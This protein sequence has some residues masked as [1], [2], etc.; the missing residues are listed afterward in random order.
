MLRSYPRVYALGHRAIEELLADPVVVQEKVDGSQFSFGRIDGV[1]Y[2]RSKNVVIDLDN[3]DKRFAPAIQTVLGFEERLVDGV[4]FRGEVLNRPKH[5]TLQYGRAP[6][7]NIVLFDVDQ[8][9]EAYTPPVEVAELAARLGLEAVP[10]L[11]TGKLASFDQL[12][13]LLDRESFLGGTKIEGVVIK[14]YHRF[15]ID[16][17]VLMGKFV[18]ESFKEAHSADWG[19]RNPKHE[20]F[21]IALGESL[22]TDARWVKGIEHLRDAGL[23]TGSPKDIGPLL[24]EIKRD[25]LEEEGDRLAQS[26]LSHASKGLLSLAT[27]G[28]PEWYKARLAL[29]Q[30]DEEVERPNSQ[31]NMAPETDEK[32]KKND[33]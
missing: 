13:Q 31:L 10:T 9:L 24:V 20:D 8:G 3:P 23:L 18:S 11:Y 15:G 19:E 17:K 29:S 12:T 2:V 22:R 4:T 21:L 30:F 16:K 25:I 5:N 14:N 32:E 1:L 26:L 27:R 7:G 6:L 28:F 33:D